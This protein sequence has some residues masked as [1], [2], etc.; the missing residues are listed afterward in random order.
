[1]KKLIPLIMVVM[2]TTLTLIGCGTQEQVTQV[3][4]VDT[5][6]QP[7]PL[8]ESK[9]AVPLG[10]VTVAETSGTKEDIKEDLSLELKSWVVSFMEEEER[11]L[12]SVKVVVGESEKLL[13]DMNNHQRI[14][15]IGLSMMD[16]VESYNEIN[17]LL[18]LPL[19]DEGVKI[20][21]NYI[22]HTGALL[23]ST[24]PSIRLLAREIDDRNPAGI[25]REI[26]EIKRSLGY[27]EMDV[28]VERI[29]V[30]KRILSTY[31]GK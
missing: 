21:N 1:M 16:A 27:V 4:P 31:T 24:L 30:G 10:T 9:R 18:N 7:N 26:A 22:H 20:F 13:S 28:L 14:V 2:I 19:S 5:S 17:R 11:Y 25:K 15:T 12:R 29:E 23:G 6:V 8:L 3:Q